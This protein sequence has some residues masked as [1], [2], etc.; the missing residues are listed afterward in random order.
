MKWIVLLFWLFDF[1][2]GFDLSSKEG[3]EK[4]VADFDKI[5]G[6]QYLRAMHL[7]DS[8]GKQKAGRMY[9]C[10]NTYNRDF[11]WDSTTFNLDGFKSP[12]YTC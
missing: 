2:S 11:L 4:F 12:G 8:K 6:F 10:C 9:I 1:L 3:F 5:V 7:N